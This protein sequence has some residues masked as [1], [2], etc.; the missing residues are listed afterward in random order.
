MRERAPRVLLLL[1]GLLAVYLCAPFIASIGQLGSADWGS[2]DREALQSAIGISVGSATLASLLIA[3]GGIPLGYLLARSSSRAMALLGFAVQLPLALPPLASGV[4]LL[5]LLGPYSMLGSLAGGRLT[6]SFTGVVLAECFVAAPFLIVAARSAFAA[7]DPALDE[8]AATLGLNTRRRFFLVALPLA[9]PGIRAGLLLAWLRAFG[10]FGATVM[11]AYHPYSLPIYTYVA[12]GSQG[13]SAMMP[14]MLPTLVIALVFAGLSTWNGRGAGYAWCLNRLV[15]RQTDKPPTREKQALSFGFRKQ[16]DSFQLDVSWETASRRLAIIGASGS[17]KSLTL[18]LIAGTEPAVV[19]S[20][21]LDGRTLGSAPPEQR[22]IAY[23][24]QNYGLFPHLN[25]E[26]Q[27]LFSPRANA[28][29]ARHWISRLGLDGLEQ[30]RPVELSLGQCQRV[31]VARALSCHSQLVLLD[32]PFSALDTPRRRQLRQVLRQLQR[33]IDATTLL[34]THDP[35]EAALL[36]DEILVLDQGQVLQMGST[37]E[38]FSRPNCPRVAQLLGLENIGQATVDAGCIVTGQG[39]RLETAGGGFSP[40]DTVMWRLDMEKV[41]LSEQSGH[42]ALV[43]GHEIRQGVTHVRYRLG[44]QIL[45]KAS[46]GACLPEGS[47]CRLLIPAS[48][49]TLWPCGVGR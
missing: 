40:G 44:S 39:L 27:L 26:Q 31:A 46:H 21:S 23:V 5:I 35:D 34:V 11:V 10:E 16:L 22:A 25:V 30:R 18:R 1:A 3:L 28:Q 20:M 33:E 7:Q 43:D 12:F 47:H 15:R 37:Q 49:I 6:D 32:E 41:Q 36:A 2:V 8:V 19:S 48:A 45:V 9:W 17:G 4:L 42:D 13:L 29:A 38:L 14:L 24:P